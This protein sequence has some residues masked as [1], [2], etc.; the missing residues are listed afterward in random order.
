MESRAPIQKDL[1]IGGMF[2]G[3]AVGVVAVGLSTGFF[4]YLRVKAATAAVRRGWALTTVVVAAEDLHPGEKVV[5]ERISQRNI[6]EQIVTSSVI[7]PDSASYVLNLPLSV[8]VKA[9]DPMLWSDFAFSNPG[10]D[11][12]KTDPPV[13]EECQ[14]AV[15]WSADATADATA[16]AIRARVVGAR[17]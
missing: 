6:P 8:P 2:T 14:K 5:F 7:K 10:K 3:I 12:R 9:G 16:E 17:R 1:F 15:G 4:G 11:V 13:F